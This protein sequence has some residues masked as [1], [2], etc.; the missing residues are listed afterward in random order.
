MLEVDG[1]TIIGFSDETDSN[2]V[3]GIIA[4]PVDY[5]VQAE[6]GPSGDL[7]ALEYFDDKT[8]FDVADVFLSSSRLQ[9]TEFFVSN[10]D[11]SD[12]GRTIFVG[13]IDLFLSRGVLLECPPH[14]LE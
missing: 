9:Q 2:G 12:G 7:H 3:Y 8:G 5:K 1:S 14:P 4:P 6:Q 11:R 13:L 10:G